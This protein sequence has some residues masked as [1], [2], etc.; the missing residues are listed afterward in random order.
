MSI[1]EL[2]YVWILLHMKYIQ[3]NQKFPQE[4]NFRYF[5][6]RFENAKICLREKIYFK[7]KI[8][9]WYMYQYN[10]LLHTFRY[11]TLLHWFQYLEYLFE[12]I[13]SYV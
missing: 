7:R 10:I 2:L 13:I 12:Y 3:Y 5:R 4:S 1:V 11:R 9:S 8:R 6:E